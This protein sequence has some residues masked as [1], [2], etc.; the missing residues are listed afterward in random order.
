MYST[1]I[2]ILKSIKNVLIVWGIPALILLVDN[3]TQWIPDNYH[4]L[5]IPVMGLVAYFT[6]N[7]IGNK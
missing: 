4:Q 1:K 6:K 7:W 2:G 3:W 5:A